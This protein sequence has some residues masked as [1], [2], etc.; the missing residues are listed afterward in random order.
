MRKHQVSQVGEA[1]I[2]TQIPVSC[3]GE[4]QGNRA[5]IHF[6][7]QGKFLL[8]TLFLFF[9]FWLYQGWFHPLVRISSPPGTWGDETQYTWEKQRKSDAPRGTGETPGAESAGSPFPV[10]TG[11]CG[12]GALMGRDHLDTAQ[13][14][15]HLEVKG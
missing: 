2:Q 10:G 5:A 15:T 13:P 8:F 6:P 11:L 3:S 1:S 7:A 14:A 9:F 12:I 4:L